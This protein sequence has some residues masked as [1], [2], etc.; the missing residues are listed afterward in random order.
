[1]TSSQQSAHFFRQVKGR[2]QTGQVFVGKSDLDR[3]RAML[4]Y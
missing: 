4:S 3:W 1:M 2:S